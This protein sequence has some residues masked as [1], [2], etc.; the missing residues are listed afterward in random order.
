MMHRV[1]SAPRC[2]FS[3]SELEKGEERM[4]GPSAY[5]KTKEGPV[6]SSA[7][8]VEAGGFTFQSQMWLHGNLE[9]SLGYRRL[10]LK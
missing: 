2:L 4:E 10:P 5:L 3:L 6:V 1:I 9:A 7:W 8:K